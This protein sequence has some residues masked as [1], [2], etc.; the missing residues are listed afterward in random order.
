LT[1]Q[2]GHRLN[3]EERTVERRGAG[4]ALVLPEEDLGL[5][6]EVAARYLDALLA[7]DRN[8]A[9][10]AALDNGVARG[11]SVP[12]LYLGV[13]QPAQHRVGALWQENRL[14]VAHEHVATAISQLVMALAYPSLPREP[15]NGKRALVACV[16]DELHDLGARMA[17][18]FFEMAGFAVRYLGAN[19]PAESLAGMVREEQPDLA[20]LSVTMAFHLDAAREA[21]QRLREVGGDQ[22]RIAIGGQAFAWSPGLPARLGADVH[23]RSAEESVA[24]ARRALGL[25]GGS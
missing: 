6:A 19:L 22:L 12:D 10:R 18:D 21:V 7:G 20:I 25:V 8:A 1:Q 14:T 11:L 17:A 15:S 24:A 2:E 9:V 4:G 13:I 16:D 5:R 23:G 3:D